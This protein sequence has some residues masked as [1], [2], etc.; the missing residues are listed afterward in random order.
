[1]RIHS[2]YRPFKCDMCDKTFYAVGNLNT[3]KRL[4]SLDK[5]YK[6]NKCPE[7]FYYHKT[8]YKHLE[9]SHGILRTRNRR[10]LS[11]LA[12]KPQKPLTTGK[13]GRPRKGLQ[14]NEDEHNTSDDESPLSSTIESPEQPIID[15]V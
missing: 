9:K 8:F 10:D 13:R 7:S 15:G 4:H 14:Q 1:M 2:T 5:P 12:L 3:H 6:C 11:N